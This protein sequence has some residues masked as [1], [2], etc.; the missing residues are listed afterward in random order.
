MWKKMSRDLPIFSLVF[1][2]GSDWLYQTATLIIQNYSWNQ[3]INRFNYLFIPFSSQFGCF[4]ANYFEFD[5]KRR[6]TLSQ[7][8]IWP[9][10]RLKN[11]LIFIQKYE[12]WLIYER[13]HQI[14]LKTEVY[15]RFVL[16]INFSKSLILIICFN[17]YLFPTKK[18]PTLFFNEYAGAFINL[19]F[20]D[21]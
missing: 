11:C 5:I 18:A 2:V 1:L 14:L 3:R 20:N 4:F 6:K 21:A 7:L 13:F 10:K 15:L 16:K 8:N 17:F 9:R 19:C 12:F